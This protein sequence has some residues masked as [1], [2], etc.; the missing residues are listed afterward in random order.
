[1]N[2]YCEASIDPTL[3]QRDDDYNNRGYEDDIS[4]CSEALTE[5][6]GVRSGHVLTFAE[7]V[8]CLITNAATWE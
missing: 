5:A 7:A 3:P 2:A 1:M 4:T 6:C 8:T